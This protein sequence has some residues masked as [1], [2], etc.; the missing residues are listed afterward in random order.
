[1]GLDEED[2]EELELRLLVAVAHPYHKQSCETLL[3]SDNGFTEII[4]PFPVLHGVKKVIRDCYIKE[5]S[6][7]IGNLFRCTEEFYNLEPK[8]KIVKAMI[9]RQV[10]KAA[11]TGESL[12]DKDRFAILGNIQIQ[13]GEHTNKHKTSCSTMGQLGLEFVIAMVAYK[14]WLLSKSLTIEYSFET[15]QSI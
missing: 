12:K 5:F 8:Y 4:N 3:Y 2:Q 11:T 9:F 7:F 14:G 10:N 15:T 1:M 6:P 13:R